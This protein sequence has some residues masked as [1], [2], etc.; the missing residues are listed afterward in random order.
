M[1][2]QKIRLCAIAM[3]PPRRSFFIHLS[4][5]NRNLCRPQIS[6]GNRMNPWFT[7]KS[8]VFSFV[9]GPIAGRAH[10]SSTPNP[11]Q[12]GRLLI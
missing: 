7:G 4:H 6:Q 3:R 1:R 9:I 11:V 10:Y 8:H 5:A 12:P 2:P